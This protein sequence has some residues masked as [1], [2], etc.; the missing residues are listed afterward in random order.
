LTN[1]YGRTPKLMFE[2]FYGGDISNI[3]LDNV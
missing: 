1:N 3:N 2:T